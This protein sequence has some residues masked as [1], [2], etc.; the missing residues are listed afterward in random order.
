MRRFLD[1]QGKVSPVLLIAGGLAVA[2]L[3]YTMLVPANP[4]PVSL[5]KPSASSMPAVKPGAPSPG[6]VVKPGAPAPGAAPSSK[7]PVAPAVSPLPVAD[8]GAASVNTTRDPF[9]PGKLALLG[10]KDS[11]PASSPLYVGPPGS[12]PLPPGKTPEVGDG[13]PVYKGSAKTES[14]QVA[15]VVYR[16]KSYILQI[17]D[18]LP[19]TDY[20]L[21]QIQPDV[22]ILDTGSEQ[23]RLTKKREAK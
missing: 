12:S 1:E 18:R 6:P 5:E 9:A 17:G 21:A 23:L 11:N 2:A 22:I 7:N 16:N 20:R 4:P 3:A 15:I 14:G 10:L 13:K 19:T 8:P